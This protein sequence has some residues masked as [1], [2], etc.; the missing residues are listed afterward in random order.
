MK[1]DK[2]ID[3]YG[4]MGDPIGHSKSPAIHQQFAE[5]TGELLR[6]EALHVAAE[7][8]DTAVTEF[9][10]SGGKGLN[11][12][13]PH[14]E[15]AFQKAEVLTER[16]S[17]AEAVNTLYLN[18]NGQL[19]GDN[20]D[21]AGL[22]RDLKE[23]QSVCIAGTSVLLLGAGG[24]SRGVLL[25]L[26]SEGLS[27][28]TIANRTAEKAIKL[29]DKFSVY[30]PVTGCG[31]ET[32]AETQFDLVI[33]ATSAGLSGEVPPIAEALV[34]GASCYD[35]VYGNEPTAFLRWARTAGCANAVD[36]LGMLVEQAAESFYIWRN[37]RPDTLPVMERLRG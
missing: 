32:L 2:L 14:K 29:A 31:Y 4:V 11:I 17:L 5:Q 18:A 26:L 25:P 6:Y 24:A 28:I 9:F 15:R 30:G 21:G 34:R 19:C 12:T 27:A 3:R 1:N 8:F 10:R 20:T 37:V 35:M 23:N 16:A 13:V 22:V 7:D 36:G 33:N